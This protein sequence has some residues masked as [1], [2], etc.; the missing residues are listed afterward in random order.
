MRI[1]DALFLDVDATAVLVLLIFV[2]SIIYYTLRARRGHAFAFRP[3]AAYTHMR[4]LLSYAAESGQ[5][6]HLTMGR[7]Q[8]GGQAT[9][10]AMMGITAYDYIAHHLAPYEQAAPGTTGSATMMP[11]AMGMLQRARQDAALP[12]S[13]GTDGA[14]FYGPDSIAYAAGAHDTLSRRKYLANIMIGH[15]DDDGLWIA[16]STGQKE[17]MQI[18]GTYDPAAA[19]LMSLSVDEPLIGEELY[20]AGAYLHRR[21]HLGSLAAQDLLRAIVILAIVAGVALSSLG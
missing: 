10:E 21:S 11:A 14:R 15:F 1:F 3:I 7:G 19:M 12:P 9:P 8:I 17:M 4:R 20:G 2:P 18:G 16:E 13:H 5:P 6:I